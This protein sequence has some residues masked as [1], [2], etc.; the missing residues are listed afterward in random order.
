MIQ[1]TTKKSGFE[2]GG[3]KDGLLGDGGALESEA[4]L[5]VDRLVRGKQA[6]FEALE[7]IEVFEARDGEIR[8]DE[9][10]IGGVGRLLGH[11]FRRTGPQARL[12]DMGNTRAARRPPFQFVSHGRERKFFP[13]KA[14]TGIAADSVLDGLRLDVIDDQHF[15]WTPGLFELK[16]KLFADCLRQGQRVVRIGRRH[17]V[18]RRR[19]TGF[20][21]P[22][23][24]V[25]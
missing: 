4:L 22:I 14:G 7:F 6:G 11:E 20:R 8:A 12:T 15:H 16:A 25:L 21:G 1:T 9:D 19:R 3:P 5:G 18:R 2:A 13:K 23:A 10:G 24:A 17:R